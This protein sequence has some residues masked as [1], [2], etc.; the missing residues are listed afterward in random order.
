MQFKCSISLSSYGLLR[1]TLTIKIS[2]YILVYLVNL[3][4]LKLYID[5]NLAIFKS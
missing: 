2:S 3:D 1:A 4:L 5:I